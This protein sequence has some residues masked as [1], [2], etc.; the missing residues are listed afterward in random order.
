[1]RVTSLY[2]CFGEFCKRDGHIEEWIESQNLWCEA[3]AN[4]TLPSF[5]DV[6]DRWTPDERGKIRRL[7]AEEALEFPSIDEVVLPSDMLV[8]RAFTTMVQFSSVMA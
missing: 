5:H 8:K 1:M 3:Y 2:L 4:I 7:Q 6:V